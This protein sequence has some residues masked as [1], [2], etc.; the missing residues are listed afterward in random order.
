MSMRFEMSHQMKLGQQLSPKMIQ[1]MEI[2]QLPLIDLRERV[3]QE[4][5]NNPILELRERSSE[6]AQVP[7]EAPPS[8]TPMVPRR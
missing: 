6:T 7:D 5:A 8:A 3:E 4:L 2:L 1:S